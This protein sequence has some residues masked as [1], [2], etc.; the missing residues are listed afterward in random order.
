ME[1]DRISCMHTSCLGFGSLIYRLKTEHGFNELISLCQSV[2]KA[3]EA[4]PALPA[5]LVSKEFNLKLI[6]LMF[7]VGFFLKLCMNTSGLFSLADPGEKPEGP[8]PLFE[9]LK[10]L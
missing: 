5:K 1:I 7:P 6:Y 2:W 3:V 9:L 10:M 8:G 4:D